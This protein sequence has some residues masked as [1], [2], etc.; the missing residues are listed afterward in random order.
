MNRH[1]I[2][3]TPVTKVLSGIESACVA[4]VRSSLDGPRMIPA[5]HCAA[6]KAQPS[7]P[8]SSRG[9]QYSVSAHGAA[10]SAVPRSLLAQLVTCPI[11]AVTAFTRI[12]SSANACSVARAVSCDPNREYNSF[13]SAT[14]TA[15]TVCRT[16]QRPSGQVAFS[17]GPVQ[18]H[19]AATHLV[20]LQ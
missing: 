10:T 3:S 12:S 4:R 1:A 11:F 9:V 17:C 16:R 13:M 6:R 20:W 5:S 18:V 7:P 15:G 14:S 2:A 19:S 8:R